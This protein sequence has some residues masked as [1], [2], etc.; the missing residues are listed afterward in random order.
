MGD[1]LAALGIAIA[2]A[3]PGIVEGASID[4]LRVLRE[5][6]LSECGRSA[7]VMYG[8]AGDSWADDRSG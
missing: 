8:M 6:L 1:L 4:I 3:I 5:A 7:F 2:I